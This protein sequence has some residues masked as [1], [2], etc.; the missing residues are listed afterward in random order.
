[1]I[2]NS[3]L[4]PPKK[5]IR[6]FKYAD[7]FGSTFVTDLSKAEFDYSGNPKILDQSITDFCTAFSTP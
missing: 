5:D 1:M 2:Q 3:G 7:H 4:R 6:D